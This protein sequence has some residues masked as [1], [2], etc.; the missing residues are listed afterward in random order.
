MRC[1]SGRQSEEARG[2]LTCWWILSSGLG[3]S[4]PAPMTIFHASTY[5]P[6]RDSKGPDKAGHKLIADTWCICTATA[7]SS[8]SLLRAD[9]NASGR[10][11][12]AGSVGQ[13]ASAPAVAVK[14]MGSNLAVAGTAFGTTG[15]CAAGRSVYDDLR[16]R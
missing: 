1:G 2:R 9:A 12:S 5:P 4:C 3:A 15:S 14:A 11:G 8:S 7:H 6:A 16:V 10:S 13:I